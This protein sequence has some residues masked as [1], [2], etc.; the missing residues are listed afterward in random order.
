MNFRIL[1]YFLTVAREQN[2]T[3]AAELLHI[4]QP[5]LSRQLMQLEKEL[6]VQLFERA[7]HKLSLTPAG[8]LL[9][10]RAQDILEMV[11]KT[12]LDLRDQESNLS[13]NI[14]FGA[15]EIN[16]VNTLADII[17]GFQK[18]FPDVS[19]DLFTNTT[20]V[21]K[22]KME[23]GLLD[24]ALLQE[25]IDMTNYNFL[26]LPQPE[27]LGILMRKDAELASYASIAPEDLVHKQVV[28]PS[29]LN[30]RSSILN[31][32]SSYIAQIHIVGTCNLLCN[33]ELLVERNNYYAITVEIPARLNTNLCF[34]ALTPAM[35]S[36][37]FLAWRRDIRQSLT[38]QKF[39]AFARSFLEEK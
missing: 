12:E 26:K 19:F 8:N 39:I 2:I 25:P 1:T 22:E 18:Q 15:G 33:V 16:A 7:Q 35:Q 20:D 37:V 38:V 30:L 21:I 36:Q 9:V 3:R 27:V 4:T 29:R 32:R 5:T 34:R 6:G 10:H 31:W 24:I 14:A 13:G 28:L 17:A 11:E 23:Q